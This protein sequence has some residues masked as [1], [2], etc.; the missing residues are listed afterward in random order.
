ML[1][2]TKVPGAGQEMEPAQAL[3]VRGVQVWNLFAKVGKH[4]S[5][6]TNP[7]ITEETQRCIFKE[8][9]EVHIIYCMESYEFA[10]T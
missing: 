2:L 8:H 4:S 6:K 1:P 9:T 10:L 7:P 3:C 5:P